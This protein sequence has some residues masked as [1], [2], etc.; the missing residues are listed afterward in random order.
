MTNFTYDAEA[1]RRDAVIARAMFGWNIDESHWINQRRLEQGLSLCTTQPSGE[2][3]TLDE[4]YAQGPSEKPGQAC[5]EYHT[6]REALAEALAWFNE[7]ADDEQ[8]QE[9]F[10][11]ECGMYAAIGAPREYQGTRDVVLSA[12]TAPPHV[13]AA[14]LAEAI[15]G[16]SGQ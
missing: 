14:A 16:G 4:F 9:F 11:G 2:W 5:P 10:A 13:L 12:L 3:E 1:R 15:E 6:D 8:R 7:S